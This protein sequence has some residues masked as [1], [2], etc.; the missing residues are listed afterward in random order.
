MR[1]AGQ[2]GQVRK[3]T[4]GPG[5]QTQRGRHGSAGR[6]GIIEVQAESHC[7][8]GA[9][10]SKGKTAEN[11]SGFPLLHHQ[12]TGFHH[13]RI[14]KDPLVQ[15]LLCFLLLRDIAHCMDCTQKMLIS[16]NSGS[17]RISNQRSFISTS[18]DSV[19]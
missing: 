18:I 17:T 2:K 9:D 11:R 4:A 19:S 12:L 10:P 13:G 7:G 5:K 16:S 8:C 1:G 14:V 15:L 6:T 3:G